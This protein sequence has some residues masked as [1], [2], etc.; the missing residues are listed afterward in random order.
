MTLKPQSCRY[1]MTLNIGEEEIE[2]VALIEYTCTPGSPECGPSYASGG[3]PAE[4]PE[5]D[6]VEV[7]I[8]ALNK[9]TGKNVRYAAPQWL[10]D[11]VTENEDVRQRLGD[12]ADWGHEGPDP[13]DARDREIERRR[14][15]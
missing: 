2:L 6:F 7:E 12:H 3:E 14:G 5:I 13:D 1:P 15:Q 9:T 8:E 11:Y 10:F 4:A